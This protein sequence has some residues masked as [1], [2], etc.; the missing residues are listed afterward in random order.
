M[1]ELISP[2]A[3]LYPWLFKALDLHWDRLG[4]RSGFVIHYR[5]P[6]ELEELDLSHGVTR[7]AVLR[8]AIHE[9]GPGLPTFRW[10]LGEPWSRLADEQAGRVA[11]E[12][13]RRI[14]PDPSR[15]QAKLPV[16]LL[17]VWTDSAG[18]PWS[19]L[20]RYEDKPGGRVCIDRGE[21]GW[22]VRMGTYGRGPEIGPAGRAAAD[23][24][25]IGQGA[26]LVEQIYGDIPA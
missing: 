2:L 19:R 1:H 20:Q 5:E 22:E 11:A 3:P 13:I 26:I 8:A 24:Y 7:Y 15:P 10:A 12:V 25:A 9:I 23:A 16:C 18:S 17:G 21:D 4:S 14:G 6:P